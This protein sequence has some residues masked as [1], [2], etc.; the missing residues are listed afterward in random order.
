M[1]IL[2]FYIYTSIFY[3]GTYVPWYRYCTGTR[4]GTRYCTEYC[5]NYEVQRAWGTE[6]PVLYPVPGYSVVG[7]RY[8][9]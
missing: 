3:L 2:T 5:T 8:P 4:T 6:Y 9:S 1:V 7:T